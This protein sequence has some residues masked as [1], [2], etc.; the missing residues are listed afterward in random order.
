MLREHLPKPTAALEASPCE[1]H[2]KYAAEEKHE[3]TYAKSRIRHLALT[4]HHA[5]HRESVAGKR[6]KT[7]AAPGSI[8]VFSCRHSLTVS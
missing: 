2:Q 5:S 1:E 7:S 6:N 4:E 3:A 8:Q